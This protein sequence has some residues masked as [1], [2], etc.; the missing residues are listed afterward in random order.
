MLF[1]DDLK[2]LLSYQGRREM[3]ATAPLK[4]R[5]ALRMVVHACAHICLEEFTIIVKGVDVIPQRILL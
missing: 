2:D 3:F 5:D 4:I 1:K